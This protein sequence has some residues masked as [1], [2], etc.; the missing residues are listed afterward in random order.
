MATTKQIYE[1]WLDYNLYGMGKSTG[2][3]GSHTYNQEVYYYGDRPVQR[4]FKRPGKRPVVVCINGM[5][6]KSLRNE[7]E[8]IYVE[9]L[10][11]FSQYPGDMLEG[12]AAH[13]RQRYMMLCRIQNLVDIE[14]PGYT[15]EVCDNIRTLPGFEK[16]IGGFYDLY[17]RYSDLFGLHWPELPR[18]YRERGVHQIIS[19]A[20]NWSDPKAIQKRERAAA[21]RLANKAL[22]LD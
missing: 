5:F 20:E 15:D 11:V 4:V 16:K 13:D 12:A 2:R 8:E 7:F 14:V 3:Q 9:D 19:K 6:P 17:R 22:G 21:K 18:S 10:A 1:R